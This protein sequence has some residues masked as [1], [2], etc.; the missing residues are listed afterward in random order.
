MAQIGISNITDIELPAEVYVS[1]TNGQYVSLIGIIS[2][3]TTVPPT[4]IYNTSI[5]EIFH[6]APAI[7]V[8]IVGNDG[9]RKIKSFDCDLSEILIV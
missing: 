8:T 7:A 3:G 1:T 9:C 6:S 2:T 5:P 4:I